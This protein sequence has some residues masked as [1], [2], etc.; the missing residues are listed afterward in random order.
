MAEIFPTTYST[1]AAAPL[2]DLI[3]KK[4]GW[5]KM[6]C[7]LLLRG[8]SDTYLISASSGAFV[9][10][11]YRAG[12]RSLS[13]IAAE[14]EFLTSLKNAGVSVS[15]PLAD[16]EG[17]YVFTV[18]AVEGLRY[19]VVFKYARGTVYS[20]PSE[21]QLKLF[22]REMAKFHNVSTSVR[23]GNERWNFDIETTLHKPLLEIRD[24]FG[25]CPGEYAWLA[26][27]VNDVQRDL[28]RLDA[29]RFSSGYCHF[30]FFPKNI[31]FDGDESV[32]FFDFDFFGYGWIVNDIMTFQQYLCLEAETGRILEHD[33]IKM[34]T[35]FMDAYREIRQMSSE[36]LAA[37]PLLSLGFWMFYLGF[38]TTHDQFLPLLQA[39]HLTNRVK[40]MRN[41]MKRSATLKYG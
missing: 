29:S 33:A 7:Q 38:Y 36:E 22:G 17:T 21:A 12:H 1:L 41:I 25:S 2:A 20:P 23:L 40:L 3:S 5:D 16:T 15:Y 35:I 8:V 27:A 37:I 30:D 11:I 32:T 4:Y 19:G 18:P 34:F 6:Q 28:L 39:P 31:H 10:R 24:Y 9:V 13:H 14:V 26:T